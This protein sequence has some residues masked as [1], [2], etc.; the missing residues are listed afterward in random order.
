ML[1]LFYTYHYT[2]DKFDSFVKR[3]FI[4][5]FIDRPVICALSAN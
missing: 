1:T 4:I 3:S 2:F 5:A